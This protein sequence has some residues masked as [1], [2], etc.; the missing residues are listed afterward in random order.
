MKLYF[1]GVKKSGIEKKKFFSLICFV[2][3]NKEQ[4][5][6]INNKNEKTRYEGVESKLENGLIIS[7]YLDFPS[8]QFKIQIMENKID[9]GFKGP[10]K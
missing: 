6:N 4:Y 2:Y 5:V 7:L 1:S 8:W 3:F 9:H 10:F